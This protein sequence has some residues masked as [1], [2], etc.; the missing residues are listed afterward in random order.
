MEWQANLLEQS[1]SKLAPVGEIVAKSF[2]DTLFQKS[3]NLMPL[4][5][6]TSMKDLH[7]KFWST[8]TFT[9]QEFRNPEQLTNTLLE[10][11]ANHKVYGVRPSDY[12]IVRVTLLKTLQKFLGE[13]WSTEMH[14]AW[15]M[16]LFD[17]SQIMIQGA[18]QTHL[19]ESH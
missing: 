11:G 7:K 19:A 1:V 13:S 17:V 10:L 2:Y 8:L 12:D 14:L 15:S 6:G 18:K 4:F 5:R 3:P 16:A 9:A